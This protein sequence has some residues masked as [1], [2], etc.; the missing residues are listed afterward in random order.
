MGQRSFRKHFMATRQAS[1]TSRS[2]MDFLPNMITVM[3]LC[4]GLTAVRF[5]WSH[6]WDMALM[7][8]L[9]AA[10]LD[11]MDGRLARFLGSTSDFGAEL[12]SLSDFLCFGAAPAFLVYAVSFANWSRLGWAFCL[13]FATCTALRLARFNVYRLVATKVP[14]GSRFSIG[15]PAPAG[16]F[17]GL[18]PLMAQLS[19]D[20]SI[21]PVF[22]CLSLGLSA[23]LMISR[24]PT[25][26]FKNIQLSPRRMALSLLAV[27]VVT[28]GLLTSPWGTLFFIGLVYL[29][30]IPLSLL[31]V[32]RLKREIAKPAG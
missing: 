5:A 23:F 30:S 26:I 16:A 6:L 10:V 25:F 2:L 22:F 18:L 8:I 24:I 19:F 32:R 9:I 4:A 20:W 31:H 1:G 3:A 11:G 15:V 7:A 13:F 17:I 27:S 21:H 14:W 12:D 29:A 28:A